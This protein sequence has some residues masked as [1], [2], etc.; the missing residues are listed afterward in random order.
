MLLQ[1]NKGGIGPAKLVMSRLPVP[2]LNIIGR[3]LY[4]HIG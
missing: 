4:R 2:A 1:E 3:L